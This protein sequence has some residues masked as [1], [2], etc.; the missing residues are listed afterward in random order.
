MRAISRKGM[1]CAWSARVHSALLLMCFSC[2]QEVA[3]P[4]TITNRKAN[5]NLAQRAIILRLLTVGKLLAIVG[6]RSIKK[7]RL[8]LS[9][10]SLK[11]F[12]V[13]GVYLK[14]AGKSILS[15]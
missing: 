2:D 7:K 13:Q 15:S 3:Q 12:R 11:G 8:L 5:A 1:V 9:I 6:G 10:R 4:A 14:M